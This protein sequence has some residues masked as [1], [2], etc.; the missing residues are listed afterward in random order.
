V[1]DTVIEPMQ[2]I[3]ERQRGIAAKAKDMLDAMASPPVIELVA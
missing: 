2:G 1:L 3:I